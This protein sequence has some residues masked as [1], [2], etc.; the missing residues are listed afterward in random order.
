MKIAGPIRTSSVIATAA[1]FSRKDETMKRV[2]AVTAL[3][4]TISGSH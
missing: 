4:W 2:K 1:V 3:N